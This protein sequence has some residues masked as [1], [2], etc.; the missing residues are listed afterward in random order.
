MDSLHPRPGS[1]PRS[2][3]GSWW[4]PWKTPIQLLTGWLFVVDMPLRSAFRNGVITPLLA[5]PGRQPSALSP[6]WEL[7][8]WRGP[9][10]TSYNLF[11]SPAFSDWLREEDKDLASLNLSHPLLRLRCPQ[12]HSLHLYLYSCP[13]N[14]FI[15]TILLDS[16]YM[17]QY[18]IY[19]FF[20]SDLFHS[21]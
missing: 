19:I 20:L 8:W 4:W 17:L 21:V 10:P 5:V 18:M 6:L 16:I 2:H 1:S 12:I 13:A 7:L 3:F 15:C 9:P 14:R 11:G